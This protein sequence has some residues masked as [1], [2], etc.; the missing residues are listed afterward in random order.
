MVLWCAALL[1]RGSTSTSLVTKR[2]ISC[3]DMR[4][5]HRFGYGRA[6]DNVSPYTQHGPRIRQLQGSRQS[7]SSR[8]FQQMR[9]HSPRSP[10]LAGVTCPAGKNIEVTYGPEFKCTETIGTFA[11]RRTIT[12]TTIGVTPNRHVT[13]ATNLANIPVTL[14]GTT[15]TYLLDVTSTP[16]TSAYTTGNTTVKS[17]RD[18][19]SYR[20]LVAVEVYAVQISLAFGCIER[21]Q[22]V[23]CALVIAEMQGSREAC[24]RYP[25]DARASARANSPD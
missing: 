17:D 13:A 11:D 14:D 1:P 20:R 16:I 4:T 8:S 19:C 3:A 5:V 9:L 22:V 10:G 12:Y 21:A 15:A 18:G 2:R 7:R 24:E 6:P 23:T 25:C